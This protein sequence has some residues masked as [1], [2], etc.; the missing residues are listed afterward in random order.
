MVPG[1]LRGQVLTKQGGEELLA[2]EERARDLAKRLRAVDAARSEEADQLEA[3]LAGLAEGLSGPLLVGVIRAFSNY[4]QLVNT[5]EQHHRVRLRR[6]RDRERESEGR[7][8]SESFAAAIDAM[9]A[10]GVAPERLQSV[11]DRLTIEPVLT[12]HPTEISRRSIL[13]KHQLIAACLD[14]LDN[15]S[16]SPREHR[17]VAD[18]LLE[19]ITVMW[20]SSELRSMRPRVIDEVRRTLFVFEEVLFDAVP[21]VAE[22]ADEVLGQRYPGLRMPPSALRFSSWAGGDQDG[23]PGC[24]SEVLRE[25]LEL[26]REVASR[27]LRERVREL[28]AALGISRRM[29][30]S[31]PN[32]MPRSRPMSSRSLGL[33]RRS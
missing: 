22:H 28:S 24:T 2:T 12:A 33:P 21:D 8:Q 17:D 16:L 9:A 25:T 19:V 1:R 5:A 31:P 7:S 4:F 15:A 13:E 30:T 18:E 11:L 23:N 20:Q 29:A 26:H 3:E 27:M 14:R 6:L 32:S 10:R